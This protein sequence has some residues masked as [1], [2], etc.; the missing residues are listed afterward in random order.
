MAGT[1]TRAAG[2]RIRSRRLGCQKASDS[3]SPVAAYSI[4][5]SGFAHPPLAKAACPPSPLGEGEGL[6]P[7]FPVS[8]ASSA[9][10]REALRGKV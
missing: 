2:A 7:T 6:S 1:A 8:V 5:R 3:M 9:E 4:E 10:P